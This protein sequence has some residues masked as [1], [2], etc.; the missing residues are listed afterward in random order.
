MPRREDK[1]WSSETDN[2][3]YCYKHARYFNPSFG[4]EACRV[5]R[6]TASWQEQEAPKLFICPKCKQKSLFWNYSIKLYECLNRECKKVYTQFEFNPKS[7]EG[8]SLEV[9]SDKE[10]VVEELKKCPTCGQGMLRWNPSISK[11]ECL[12]WKCR[13]VITKEYFESGRSPRGKIGLRL[14]K[15]NTISKVSIGL[16]IMAVFTFVF[17][18]V[19]ADFGESGHSVILGTSP[20]PPIGTYGTVSQSILLHHVKLQPLHQ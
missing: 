11:Y 13:R 14:P 17:L 6:L 4:C 1:R 9:D 2:L 8:E 10:R 5:E 18:Y 15:F 12:H 20:T 3:M 19:L 16:L 7:Q